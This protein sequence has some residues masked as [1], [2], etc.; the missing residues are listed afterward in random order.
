MELTVTTSILDLI[1]FNSARMILVY[2]SHISQRD[3]QSCIWEV[4]MDYVPNHW[5]HFRMEVESGRYILAVFALKR[6]PYGITYTEQ[7]KLFCCPHLLY[8]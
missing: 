3:N 8:R 5:K 1:A 6:L 4:F 2:T 7:V